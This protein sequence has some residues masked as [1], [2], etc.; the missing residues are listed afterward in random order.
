MDLA[1]SNWSQ[2][3][4]LLMIIPMR[5]AILRIPWDNNE[6][7]QEG[8]MGGALN[9]D[10]SNLSLGEWPLIEYLY[11]DP[12]YRATYDTYVQESL[13]GAFETSHIQ[14]VYEQY[15]ALIEPYA[16]SEIQ[17]YTFLDNSSEFSAAIAELTSHAATRAAA[18][19]NYLD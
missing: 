18:A 8:K 9:L 16:T 4:H 11:N 10:F 13:D 19:E 17:G 14:G 5:K 6:A 15:A 7:L 1:R 2:P 12:V 3:F